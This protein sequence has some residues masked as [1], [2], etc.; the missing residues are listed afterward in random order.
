LFLHENVTDHEVFLIEDTEPNEHYNTVVSFNMLRFYFYISQVQREPSEPGK[1]CYWSLD[2]HCMAMFD[3]GSFLRRRRRY[4][5]HRPSAAL[6]PCNPCFIT[7]SIAVN[8]IPVTLPYSWYQSVGSNVGTV[9]DT[10]VCSRPLTSLSSCRQHKRSLSLFSVGCRSVTSE[11]LSSKKDSEAF[12]LGSANC[13]HEVKK[14][15]RIVDIL[16]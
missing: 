6:L 5:R 9:G 16:S 7:S 11:L 14:G 12:L 3:S 1:G 13:K 8:L 2:P 10:G 15:F 4:R